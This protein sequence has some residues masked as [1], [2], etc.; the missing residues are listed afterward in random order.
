M[1][2][3]E[4]SVNSS[5]A[6]KICMKLQLQQKF[7][8]SI[9]TEIS[10]THFILNDMLIFFCISCK[11][12][13]RVWFYWIRLSDVIELPSQTRIESLLKYLISEMIL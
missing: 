13:Y 3:Y 9:C 10:A 8:F 12:E 11:L 1:E 5:Y 4:I 6:G 2:K 7:L